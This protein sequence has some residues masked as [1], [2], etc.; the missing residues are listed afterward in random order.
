MLPE[1]SGV[2]GPEADVVPLA[3]A[4]E[5]AL[6]LEKAVGTT[7]VLELKTVVPLADASLHDTLVTSV[8]WIVV[9]VSCPAVAV[10][11]SVT[12]VSEVAV[13]WA[14]SAAEPEA[15]A[16]VKVEAAVLNGVLTGVEAAVYPVA[17]AVDSAAD[18]EESV[19][20]DKVVVMYGVEV[21]S[22]VETTDSVTCGVVVSST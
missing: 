21:T 1:E 13:C 3:Y 12:A 8:G 2:L 4:L 7:L 16:E 10:V 17:S 11:S 14:V 19:H 20:E 6:V 15:G 9:V 5:L 18:S 22:S